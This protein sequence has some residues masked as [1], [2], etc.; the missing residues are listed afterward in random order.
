MSRL[1]KTSWPKGWEKPHPDLD[2]TF[3]EEQDVVILEKDVIPTKRRNL[4]NTIYY[5]ILKI[6]NKI[7]GKKPKYY[8]W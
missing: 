3:E 8:E 7:L 6:F 2:H 4:Y 1:Y 5:F